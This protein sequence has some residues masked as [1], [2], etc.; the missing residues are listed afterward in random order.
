M[1]KYDYSDAVL[2][3]INQN[4]ES[5]GLLA[6]PKRLRLRPFA[7]SL[8]NSR[9]YEQFGRQMMFFKCSKMMTDANCV[10]KELSVWTEFLWG[11][12]T[13]ETRV[14]LGLPKDLYKANLMAWNV[15][16]G[17]QSDVSKFVDNFLFGN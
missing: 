5:A 9:V 16:M 12:P 10:M 1:R 11:T 15:E 2:Q 17:K 8:L 4:Y 3:R 13:V 6:F 14:E 7:T